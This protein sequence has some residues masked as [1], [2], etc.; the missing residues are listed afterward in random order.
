MQGNIAIKGTRYGLLLTLEPETPFSDLLGALADRL[1]EAP[2]FFRGASLSVDTSRRGLL[3]SERRQLED[4]LSY[5]YMS[6]APIEQSKTT[7]NEIPRMITLPLEETPPVEASIAKEVQEVRDPRESNDT[8]F[9][10]RTVRSGQA[11]HHSSNVVVLGDVNPGAEI[12]A[13][14]DIIVWGV[15]RGMVHAGYPD[16]TNALVCSLLLSPVQ[17]RIAHLLS[18]PPEGF[19]AQPRPEIASIKNE[20]IIVE[21]W[22]NGRMSRK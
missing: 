10:H 3:V 4:L 20:Q 17:L 18:R 6:V 19:E 5:Y 11:I 21:T 2:A 15:L 1:A 9:L 22:T 13:G 14:G 8:L 12:V 7:H 16:N